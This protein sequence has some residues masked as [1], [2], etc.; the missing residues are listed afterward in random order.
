MASHSPRYSSGPFARLIA[1]G[2]RDGS[3]TH[4][5]PESSRRI[6]PVD[7]R[8]ISRAWVEYSVGGYVVRIVGSYERFTIFLV[9][10]TSRRAAASMYFSPNEEAEAVE[11]YLATVWTL[12]AKIRRPQGLGFSDVTD[13]IG[14]LTL[15]QAT[16][17]DR[18]AEYSRSVRATEIGAQDRQFMLIA[19]YDTDPRAL[20]G[21]EGI[22]DRHENRTVLE[23][24]L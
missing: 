24:D 20:D 16:D 19:F 17:V 14:L 4:A 7:E 15:R 10:T 9:D 13:F 2:V 22:T 5:Q 23:V 18:L 12:G 8:P 11:Q 6:S 21:V 3:A 1:R